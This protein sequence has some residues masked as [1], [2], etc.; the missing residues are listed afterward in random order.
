VEGRLATLQD[1]C[2]KN[3]YCQALLSLSMALGNRKQPE[4]KYLLAQAVK[5]V[6]EALDQEQQLSKDS[7]SSAYL[8]LPSQAELRSRHLQGLAV[9]PRKVPIPPILVNRGKD[10]VDLLIPPFVPLVQ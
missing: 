10:W 4:Q 7:M 5:L 8:L 6:K 9:D 3:I 2:N 1:Q